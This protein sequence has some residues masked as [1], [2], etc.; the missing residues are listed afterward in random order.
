MIEAR[1]AETGDDRCVVDLR[2]VEFR[3]PKFRLGP[4]SLQIRPGA[5]VALVGPNGAGKTTLLGILSGHRVIS[6]GRFWILGIERDRVDPTIREQ[7]AIVPTELLGLRWMRVGEH[8]DF[9]SHFYSGWDMAK[10]REMADALDLHL[11]DRLRELSRGQSLKVSFCTALAQGAK[12]LLFDE[13][14]A[15][16]DPVAR[17][18]ALQLIRSY[19]RQ[20]P[21]V[22]IV[23]ATHI[24]EDLDE[25]PFTRLLVLREGKALSP[26]G[27]GPLVSSD[28]GIRETAKRMLLGAAGR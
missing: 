12:L 1:R 26:S 9:L 6:A 8:F 3:Y 10:A 22:A 17:H 27:D 13:P 14:T 18:D 15:G 28:A 4:L 24:L 11:A 20:F 21:D 23:L 19:T 25:I 2:G 5:A 16:L 7:V